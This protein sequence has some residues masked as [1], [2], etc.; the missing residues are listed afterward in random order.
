ML[1]KMTV[2]IS[3]HEI[4]HLA[5]LYKKATGQE[6]VGRST[7]ISGTPIWKF[8]RFDGGFQRITK[9]CEKAIEKK[10]Q[11]LMESEYFNYTWTM[12]DEDVEDLVERF[13]KIDRPLANVYGLPRGGLILAVALSH[14]LGLPLIVNP[15]K[16]TK[17]TLVVDD[18]ADSGKALLG[19][20]GDPSAYVTATLFYSPQS[21]V[22]PTLWQREKERGWVKFCWESISSTK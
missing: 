8:S 12:F 11:E 15:A 3:E 4:T 2:Y 7:L 1:K 16:I 10:K 9:W 13:K 5:N 19:L 22:K 21:I 18:I 6:E 14:R 17:E 20:L